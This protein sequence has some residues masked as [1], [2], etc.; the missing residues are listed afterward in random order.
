MQN[1]TLGVVVV[2]SSR[3]DNYNAYH[4]L[5]VD[6]AEVWGSA[7]EAANMMIYHLL[8]DAPCFEVN[9]EDICGKIKVDEP[10]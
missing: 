1:C 8:Y 3:A 4:K 6:V 5:A 9:V 7:I 2:E 10:E